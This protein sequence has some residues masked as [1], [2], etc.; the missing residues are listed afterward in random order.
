MKKKLTNAKSTSSIKLSINFFMNDNKNKLSLNTIYI[1]INSNSKNKIKKTKDNKSLI[2][3]KQK[4]TTQYN[5]NPKISS[6]INEE[7]EKNNYFLQNKINYFNNTINLESN[8][9][10]SKI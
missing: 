6:Y 3:Q 9:K 4:Q 8:N 2:D 1:A 7:N 10:K 5:F